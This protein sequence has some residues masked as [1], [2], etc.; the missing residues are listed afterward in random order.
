M[1][2][3][4]PDNAGDFLNRY[5]LKNE[6]IEICRENSLPRSGGKN[7]LLERIASFIE[8][9]ELPA[10]KRKSRKVPSVPGETGNILCLGPGAIIEESY[11]N[12]EVHRAF[13][14]SEIGEHFTFNVPFCEWMK[15]NRGKKT[16]R[17]ALHKWQEIYN[18]KK[19]GKKFPIG[20]Q[21]KYNR[22]TRDFFAANPHLSREDCIRC[23]NYKKG[24]PGEHKYEDG[25]L[26]ILKEF[27][28]DK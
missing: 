1:N 17:E 12:S 13:F 18:A 2:I 19:N 23:W 16:Y 15:K 20:G 5:W 7:E 10:P 22:Y 4:L 27:Q 26:V 8:G 24:I 25:D 3:I 28:V 11:S 21:F 9:R 6:L 14:K